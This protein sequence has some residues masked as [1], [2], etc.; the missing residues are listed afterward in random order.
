MELDKIISKLEISNPSLILHGPK[1]VGKKHMAFE[2]VKSV[3]CG[4]RPYCG[5]CEECRKVDNGNHTDVI[6]LRPEADEEKDKKGKDISIEQV[7]EDVLDKMIFS[8]S[9]GK[10]RFVIIDQAH[11]LNQSSGNALLKSVEEPPKD[12][13]FILLTPSLHSMLKTI[14]SRCLVISVPP[15]KSEKLAE[16]LSIEKDHHLLGYADGSVSALRYYLSIE[17]QL[18]GLKQLLDSK[19]KPF[20]IISD[21]ATSLTESAKGITKADEIENM[22]YIFSFITKHLLN[23]AKENET[24]QSKIINAISEITRLSKALYSNTTSTMVLE[25]MLLELSARS[26]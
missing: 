13:V 10:K 12:T 6:V 14:V 18:T 3:L 26:I 25:N 15:L 21:T 9:S 1:G 17:D 4:K 5:T 11:R 8:S 2:I 24:D 19:Y 7:R 20:N 22:E 16:I 23:K